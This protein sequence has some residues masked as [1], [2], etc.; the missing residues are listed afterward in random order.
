MFQQAPPI[1]VQDIPYPIQ[2]G[3]GPSSFGPRKQGLLL[4]RVHCHQ[5]SLGPVSSSTLPF[6]K[7]FPRIQKSNYVT[8]R[9][10]TL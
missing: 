7:G 4:R 3:L 2:P 9:T 6:A 10:A 1:I 5:L 8:T